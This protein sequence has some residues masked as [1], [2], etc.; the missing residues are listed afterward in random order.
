ML[1]DLILR[2]D[3]LNLLGPNYESMVRFFFILM[4]LTVLIAKQRNELRHILPISSVCI[5]FREI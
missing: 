5:V 4:Y 1:L 3:W 2:E